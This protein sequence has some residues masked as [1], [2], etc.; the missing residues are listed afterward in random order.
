MSSRMAAHERS[1]EVLQAAVRAFA[2]GGYAG[3]TTDQVA[4]QAGVSQPYVVRMFGTKLELFLAALRRACD[5]IAGTFERVLD[6]PSFDP[7]AEDAKE[8]LGLAYTSLMAD[9]DLLRVL[10]HGFT[11]GASVPEI[12]VVA[13]QGF[14]EI[15]E[16]LGRTGWDDEQ[17]TQFLAHGMLLTVLM[18][19]GAVGPTA[20]ALTDL[21]APLAA[22]VAACVPGA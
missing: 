10:M 1:E 19:M 7:A 15:Y 12:G 20:P 22:L 13:R 21:P 8:R 2:T 18:S 3:T 11:A 17:L 6:D 5:E 4:R 16:L 9:G 14:G